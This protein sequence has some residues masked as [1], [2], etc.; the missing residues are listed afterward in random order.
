MTSIFWSSLRK[1][2]LPQVASLESRISY[3]PTSKAGVAQIA[4]STFPSSY[5]SGA[6]P[7]LQRMLAIL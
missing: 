3:D 1:L 5:S 4:T 7:T 2:I 6:I